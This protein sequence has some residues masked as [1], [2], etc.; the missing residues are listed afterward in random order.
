MYEV[1]LWQAEVEDV[2]RQLEA[3]V[4]SL[5]GTH[6]YRALEFRVLDLG[7]YK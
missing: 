5:R 3:D 6:R 7:V 1:W 4:A 2:H